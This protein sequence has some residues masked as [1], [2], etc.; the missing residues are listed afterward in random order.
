MNKVGRSPQNARPRSYGGRPCG[1]ALAPL[2]LAPGSVARRHRTGGLTIY[3]RALLVG[4]ALVVWDPHG[5]RGLAP[6]AYT[7]AVVVMWHC[8]LNRGLGLSPGPFR[9]RRNLDFNSDIFFI[10]FIVRTNVARVVSP[11]LPVRCP[12]NRS[13][14]RPTVKPYNF[15]Q[16]HEPTTGCH[17]AAHD[18]ATWHI[19]NQPKSAKCRMLTR[20]H[21]CHLS[22]YLPSHC[23][24]SPATSPADVIP[25]H[26]S[27]LRW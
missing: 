10:L 22:P 12:E 20:P 15:I 26:V 1:H 16:N 17:V 23:A 27:P 2:S 25:C 18:W 13:G 4:I 24:V 8:L 6:I 5:I 14:V 3:P 9:L 19:N 11:A 21:A 7:P